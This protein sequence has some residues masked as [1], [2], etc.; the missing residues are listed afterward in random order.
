MGWGWTTYYRI[1]SIGVEF[2]TERCADAMS[3]LG[4]SSLAGAPIQAHHLPCLSVT[5]SRQS[6][7]CPSWPKSKSTYLELDVIVHV[8]PRRGSALRRVTDFRPV[9]TGPEDALPVSS[10]YLRLF[11]FVRQGPARK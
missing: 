5:V 2:D 4:E 7:W 3:L 9:G 10:H 8:R 6:P 1:D 11:P